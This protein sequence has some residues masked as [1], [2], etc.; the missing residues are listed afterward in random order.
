MFLLW[1]VRNCV[2]TLVVYPLQTYGL[3]YRAILACC[4]FGFAIWTLNGN[5]ARLHKVTIDTLVGIVIS[6]DLF[7]VVDL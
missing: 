6:E 1:C 4:M 2:Y 5:T 3:H 7:F